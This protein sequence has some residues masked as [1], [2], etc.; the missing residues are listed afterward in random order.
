MAT[1]TMPLIQCTFGDKSNRSFDFKGM[2]RLVSHPPN[3]HYACVVSAL[4]PHKT[5]PP[6]GSCR[7]L[8][9]TTCRTSCWRCS[10]PRWTIKTSARSTKASPCSSRRRRPS[11]VEPACP[12]RALRC[13]LVLTLSLACDTVRLETVARTAVCVSVRRRVLVRSDA[14]RLVPAD[15]DPAV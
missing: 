9:P 7:F 8:S 14:E 2:P 3:P 6:I 15:A 13:I 10:R 11:S 12:C 5:R 4:M 1:K